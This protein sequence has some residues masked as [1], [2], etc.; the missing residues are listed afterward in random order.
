MDPD[1]ANDAINAANANFT[2]SPEIVAPL[3]AVI[4]GLVMVLSFT[5]N[6]F[7]V[8]HTLTHIMTLKQ[9]SAILLFCLA[10]ANLIMSVLFMPFQIIAAA[11][12]H[13]VF[14]VTPQQKSGMCQFVGFVF[15]YSTSIAVHTLAALSFDR[16]LFIVKPMVHKKVMKPWVAWLIVAAIS[17]VAV[18]FNITPFIG[19][20]EYAF[21]ASIASCL[22]VWPGHKDYVIYILVESIFPLGTIVVTTLWTFIFTR[23]FIRN[24]YRRKESLRSEEKENDHI[25]NTKIRR[26]FGI[27]GSL[28]VVNVLSFVP[29]IFIS[30]IG[31]FVG[32]ANIPPAA[33]TTVLVLYLF[34]NFTNPLV[35]SLFR[36]DLN[37]TLLKIKKKLTMMFVSDSSQHDNTHQ[38]DH[39][40]HTTVSISTVT[41]PSPQPPTPIPQRKKEQ[42][43][44]SRSEDAS[45]NSVD[46]HERVRTTS[47]DLTQ[48]A[49]H[50]SSHIA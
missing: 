46:S 18:I 32:F 17:A 11:A 39:T 24:H 44:P 1:A 35:Q 16:F 19:L 8:L 47:S 31:L 2:V 43:T 25:Y 12:G 13:W 6:T 30:V 42:V 7:I 27:F 38:S 45:L 28:L 37:E 5:A 40:H 49:T 26:V 41:R 14:G 50:D 3:L 21:S 20:G 15:G 36:R 4:V 9:S 29:Y 10:L 22:P 48:E 23:T 34:S 33:Y